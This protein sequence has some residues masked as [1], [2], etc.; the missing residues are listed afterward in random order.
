MECN[1]IN[2]RKEMVSYVLDNSDSINT[3]GIS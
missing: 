3:V 1:E 2:K